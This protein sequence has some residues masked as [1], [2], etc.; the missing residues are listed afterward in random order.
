MTLKK[1][2][3]NKSTY[4]QINLTIAI[5]LL[6]VLLLL[7][8]GISA[9]FVKCPYQ[10]EYGFACASCGMSRDFMQFLQ[11]DYSHSIN[12]HSFNIFIFFISQLVLRTLL[13]VSKIKA[14]KNFIIADI[15]F[16]LLWIIWAFGSLLF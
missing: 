7:F 8:W 4:H 15:T 16:S 11:F 5:V 13:F 2:W 9:G 10:S 6:V 14:T 1:V 3:S 12:P